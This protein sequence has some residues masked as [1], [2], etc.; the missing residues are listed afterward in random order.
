M[1]SRGV[2]HGAN[3][4]LTSKLYTS[5]EK[6]CSMNMNSSSIEGHARK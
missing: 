6:S 1:A 5:T 2:L 3:S 4:N